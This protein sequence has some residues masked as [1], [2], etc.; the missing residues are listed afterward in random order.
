MTDVCSLPQS[1]ERIERVKKL[2]LSTTTVT[3]VILAGAPRGTVE[4]E[5]KWSKF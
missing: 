2:K 1:I 5:G 3:K 4:V